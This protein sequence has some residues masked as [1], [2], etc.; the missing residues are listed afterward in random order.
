MKPPSSAGIRPGPH[1]RRL[2]AA[3]APEDGEEPLARQAPHELVALLVA[4]EEEVG[5]R[6]HE[7]TQAGERVVEDLL[8]RHGGHCDNCATKELNAPGSNSPAARMVGA[9]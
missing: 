8:R 2:A 3:G 7:G 9:W 5:L 6:V 4:A 1:E